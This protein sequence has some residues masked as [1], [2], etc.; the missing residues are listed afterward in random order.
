MYKYECFKWKNQSANQIVASLFGVLHGKIKK[1]LHIKEGEIIY[2][3]Y[4]TKPLIKTLCDVPFDE[5]CVGYDIKKS[6]ANA[7]MNMKDDYP[8]Y[9]ICDQF[10]EYKGEEIDI[11]EYVVDDILI[12]ALG[13]VVIEKQVLGWNCVKY[14]LEKQYITKEQ[15]LYVKKSSYFID[16]NIFANFIKKLKEI[17]GNHEEAFKMLAVCF[18]GGLGK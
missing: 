14:L 4:H 8:V 11:G 1:S 6:Y 17:F 10:V 12:Q 15:I 3:N 5:N 9:S 16:R 2:D 13:G 18:I 7:M